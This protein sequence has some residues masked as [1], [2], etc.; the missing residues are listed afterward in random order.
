MAAGAVPANPPYPLI[1][2]IVD[3]QGKVNDGTTLLANEMVVRQNIGIEAV[4]GATK[5]D[6]PDEPLIHED[7]QVPV[8]GAHA[9]IRKLLT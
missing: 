1:Q 9:Q 6:L 2:L 4:K 7:P 3:R 8:H 5:I